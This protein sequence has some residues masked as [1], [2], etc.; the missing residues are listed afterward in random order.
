MGEKSC[1]Q[2]KVPV[3]SDVITQDSIC[4]MGS[5]CQVSFAVENLLLPELSLKGF[6]E[7]WMWRMEWKLGRDGN[8]TPSSQ[9]R[10]ESLD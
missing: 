1:G 5:N 2:R 6:I 10:A 8:P 9:E 4:E 3:G 7:H